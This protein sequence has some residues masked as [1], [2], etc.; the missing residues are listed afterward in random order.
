MQ[1][2]R[3]AYAADS[4]AAASLFFLCTMACSQRPFVLMMMLYN[5]PNVARIDEYKTC[6]KKNMANEFIDTIHILYDTSADSATAEENSIH[7]YIADL[8]HS[9][10]EKVIIEYI[11][12]RVPYQYCFNKANS[13][14]P[15]RRIILSNADIYYDES[16]ALL[17]NFDLTGYFL[18]VTRH[19]LTHSGR[20]K[21]PY[22]RKKRKRQIR[23]IEQG[24]PI[25][26]FHDTWIFNTPLIPFKDQSIIM[27][28]VYCDWRIAFAAH[29]SGIRHYSSKEFPRPAQANIYM[30]YWQ[31]LP[32]QNLNNKN[33][34]VM[35]TANAT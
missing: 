22:A 1:K 28:T 17:E 18:T 11:R 9:Y 4:I 32:T 35:P 24:M 21:L 14:Y 12:R 23:N 19:N 7:Q 8:Q 30:P 20:R 34:C 10:P 16:L 13:L 3:A 25:P 27:G 2:K 6:L 5:E 26:F 29:T 31:H 33:L 15:N